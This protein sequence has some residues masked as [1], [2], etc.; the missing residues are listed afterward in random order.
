MVQLDCCQAEDVKYELAPFQSN[1]VTSKQKWN[2]SYDPL[3]YSNKRMY[4]LLYLSFIPIDLKGKFLAS[5]I[6]SRRM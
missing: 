2:L 5:V 4:K 1:H 6:L 3:T